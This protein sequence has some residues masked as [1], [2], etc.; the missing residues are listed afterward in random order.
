VPYYQLSGMEERRFAPQ[1][2]APCGMNCGICAA[3]LG[4]RMNGRKMQKPCKGCRFRGSPCA[5]IKRSCDRLR[6]KRINYCFECPNF[7]CERLKRLDKRYR[8]KHRM[9]MIENLRNIQTNGINEF[10]KSEQERW[11]CPTCG[12]I[13]C[14]HS[15]TCYACGQTQKG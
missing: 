13:I 10:L 11:K 15:K 4:Y 2:V 5:I 7:P 6:N 3:F 1:L 12:G 9:S 14:V 8:E